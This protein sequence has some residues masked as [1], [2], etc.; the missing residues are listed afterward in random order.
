MANKKTFFHFNFLNKDISL[1][2]QAMI[3]KASTHVKNIDMKGFVS[4][5]FDLGPSLYFIPKNG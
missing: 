3:L 4:Q 5:Y 2:I 1:D